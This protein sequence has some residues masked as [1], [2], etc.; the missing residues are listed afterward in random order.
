MRR[1]AKLIDLTGLRFSRLIVKQRSVPV[2]G[3]QCWLCIC[4][5]GSVRMVRQPNLIRGQTKSCGCLSRDQAAK[6]LLTHGASGGERPQTEYTIWSSM[7]ARC[8][9]PNHAAFHR[10]GGRGIKVCERWMKFEYFFADMGAR[11]S[12][13]HSI[14]RIDNDGNYEPSNCRW[15]TQKQQCNNSP[16]NRILTHAGKSKTLTQ[17]AT[18]FGILRSTIGVRL[19][20]GWSVSKALTTPVRKLRHAR[21]H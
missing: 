20:L 6:R 1:P 14:D 8:S 16:R 3:H 10:Y 21:G 19:G 7:R 12:K 17:W 18:E 5:C 11:P 4:D 9:N 2:G 13:A 15:A